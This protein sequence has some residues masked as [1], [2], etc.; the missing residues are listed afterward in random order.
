MLHLIV[1]N[2]EEYSI[3]EIGNSKVVYLCPGPKIG[4][5][6]KDYNHQDTTL[7]CSHYNH[8]RITLPALTE[9]K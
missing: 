5:L 9:I 8:P 3:V 4:H 6:P 1:F 7:V 2:R